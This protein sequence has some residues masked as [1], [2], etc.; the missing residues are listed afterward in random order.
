M[1]ITRRQIRRI[2]ESYNQ[3]SEAKSYKVHEEYHD[4]ALDQLKALLKTFHQKYK[5]Q[6]GVQLARMAQDEQLYIQFDASA[7]D[8]TNKNTAVVHVDVQ[9][10]LSRQGLNVEVEIEWYTPTAGKAGL[11]RGQERLKL[12]DWA[13]P[14]VV[15]EPEYVV[16]QYVQN[17]KEFIDQ[18]LTHIAKNPSGK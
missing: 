9:E 6:P 1:K 3:I 2:I 12:S 4:A 11:D 7:G 15:P 8:R 16:E 5:N 14:K 13:D 18:L 10:T 17:V